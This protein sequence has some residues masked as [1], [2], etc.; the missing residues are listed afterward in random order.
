MNWIEVMLER[1]KKIWSEER[2]PD[3]SG[4]ARREPAFGK[5]TGR[6]KLFWV[7]SE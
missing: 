6:G 4:T 2:G 7:D 5:P 1:A 3:K